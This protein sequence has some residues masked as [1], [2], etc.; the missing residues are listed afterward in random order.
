MDDAVRDVILRTHATVQTVEAPVVEPNVHTLAHP[1]SS[2][3]ASRHSATRRSMAEISS[4]GSISLIR[5]SHSSSVQSYDFTGFRLSGM[6]H[7]SFTNPL[8]D[9][10]DAVDQAFPDRRQVMQ[11][12][13]LPSQGVPSRGA[14]SSCEDTRGLPT[15]SG[16]VQLN[17]ARSRSLDAQ[18]ASL[19]ALGDTSVQL[20][21]ARSAPN[22]IILKAQ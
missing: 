20:R 6:P 13:P 19:I 21:S 15:T 4:L 9:M 22:P 16:C 5:R 7:P 3:A 1:A 11:E 2:S 17:A 18:P 8:V 10:T 12:C 14:G